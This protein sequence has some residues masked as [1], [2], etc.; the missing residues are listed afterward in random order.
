MRAWVK[1]ILAIAV[2]V[3]MTIVPA[4]GANEDT[5]TAHTF[6]VA[7]LTRP[8]DIVVDTWGVPHIR[9]GNTGD[10][11]YAQGFT[12]ARD[13]MFQLDTWRRRGLGLLSEVLGPDYVAQDRSA[14]L[15]LYRGDMAAEWASYGPEAK[16][17]ATRFA[18]GINSYLDWLGAN[19]AALPVEFRKLGYQPARW[20]PEDVVR[21][22]GHAIGENLS[23]EVARATLTCLAGVGASKYLR[24]L[25]PEHTPKVPEGLDPC[26]IPS[27]VLTVY[28]KAT[29]AVTFPKSSEVDTKAI[30]DATSGSNAWAVGPRRTATGRPILANDPHRGADALPS[31]RYLTHLSAPGLNLIGAGEPWNP[32]V[33]IG[34]NGTVAFGLTN[35]P[36][37][38]TDLYVYELD[39]VDHSRY[40][41]GSG[42]EKLTTVT[43]DIPVAGAAPVPSAL[44][45]TRHGP[46]VKIDEQA[47]RAFAVRTVWT[48]PGSSPYLGSLNFQRARDFAG[49]REAMRVWRTPGSNLV[50][51]DR[52]GDIGYVPAGL[53]PR[54]EGTGY[55]GLLPVPGDGRYEWRGFHGN[56]ELPWA[57]NP[58]GGFFAS[59][60]DY[61]IP[62]GH[63]VITNYEWQLPYRK[64]RIDEI[65]SSQPKATVRDSL[66]LQRDEKSLVATQ[67]VAHLAPLRSDDPDAAAALDLL[68]GYDGVASQESAA[69]ALFETWIMRYLHS[70]WA[71]TLLPPAAADALIRTINPDFS[72]LIESFDNP[73]EWFGQNGAQIRDTLLLDT[74]KTAFADVRAQLGADPAAWR[75]GAIHHQEFGHPLGGPNIGPIPRGGSYHTIHP[76]FYH[77]L[78][79]RQIIGATFKMALD[80][81]EWDNSRAI[82]APGQSG[83]ERSPHY[84]DLYHGWATGGSFPLLYSRAEIERNASARLRL[85]PAG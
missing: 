76:S 73:E 3:G 24:G 67:I 64:Q 55:D 21:I 80:V 18:E 49:F 35:L 12:V 14:R 25:R 39:P 43:E 29:A 7:G 81:G 63:P 51:A 75:W 52:A 17:A 41:Y 44:T 54:R 38:Q 6:T 68:R 59:A 11:F 74:L 45:F 10:L 61:N 16:L 79:Y 28:N 70:G 60:N 62:E 65:L 47:H 13:R 46:V 66:A 83:D 32:G 33:A 30:A 36:V 34:H 82:N 4:A 85:Q 71:K 5:E 26:A 40:R 15:F 56:T 2:L 22:R 77:P 23:W 58:A 84:R 72:L 27:D 50:Y 53:T 1:A 48:E 42:W 9:A 20:R 57:H 78:T 31:G 37:D 8:V 69:A 19:P